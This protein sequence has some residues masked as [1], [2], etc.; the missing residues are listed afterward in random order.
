[1]AGRPEEHLDTGE[2]VVGLI[3]SPSS[4]LAPSVGQEQ[5]RAARRQMEEEAEERQRNLENAMKDPKKAELYRK[6]SETMP[7]TSISIK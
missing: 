2:E 4:L 5:L 6:L 7:G 3:A 1:M